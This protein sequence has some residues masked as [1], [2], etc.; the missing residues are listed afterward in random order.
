MRHAALSGDSQ[1]RSVHGY[2]ADPVGHADARL[3]AWRGCRFLCCTPATQPCCYLVMGNQVSL[4]LR[5]FLCGLLDSR[6]LPGFGVHVAFDSMDYQPSA[7]AL[8]RCGQDIEF[9]SRF[10]GVSRTE[11]VLL[12]IV[13]SPGVYCIG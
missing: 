12:G 11:T 9:E 3:R 7:R 5:Q 10:L 4:S 6:H 8:H 1:Q 2:D 13:R